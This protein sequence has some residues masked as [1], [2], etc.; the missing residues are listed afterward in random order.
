MTGP[1]GIGKTRVS[2]ELVEQALGEGWFVLRAAGREQ[3]ASVPYWPLVEAVQA[4][5]LDRPEVAE[6]LGEAERAL[7]ARLTG[8]P[9][10]QQ[11]GPVHRHAVLHLVWRVIAATGASR[12]MLFLDDLHW[13]DDDTLALAEVLASASV[14]RGVLL[15]GTYR[16]G[17][18]RP[19]ATARA[20]IARRVGVE[21]ELTALNRSESDAIVVDVLKRRCSDVE[22]ALAW[23]LGEGNPV[24]A[25]RQLPRM[26]PW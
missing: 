26:G 21:I 1:A 5:M 12:T 2:E 17:M 8:L 25:G 4:A 24:R 11:S 18:E 13:V 7:L 14:P 22:L 23:E 3:T 15:L 9:V 19:P 20:M 10:E 6:G 16:P